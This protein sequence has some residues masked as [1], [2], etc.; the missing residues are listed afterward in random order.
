M[1]EEEFRLTPID[2]RAQEFN[3]TAFGYDTAGVED[4]RERVAAEMERLLKERA[5]QEERVMN[6]R[7]QL[8]SLREREKAINDAVMMAQQ[9][10]E[11]THKAAQQEAEVILREARVKAEQV[12]QESRDSEIAV[13]RDLEEAQHQFNAYLYAFRR[14]LDRQMAELDALAEHERDGSPPEVA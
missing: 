7:E 12:I 3:R 8:K 13:R 1:T 9:L 11:A 10:R 14:L 6:L 2:V 5:V 4:F